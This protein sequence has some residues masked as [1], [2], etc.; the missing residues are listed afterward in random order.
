MKH[1][2]YDS[3]IKEYRT[4]SILH[5]NGNIYIVRDNPILHDLIDTYFMTTGDFFNGHFSVI[6]TS[7]NLSH[8]TVEWNLIGDFYQ[9]D[10]VQIDEYIGVI[11]ITKKGIKIGD[12]QETFSLLDIN[13][14][15]LLGNTNQNNEILEQFNKQKER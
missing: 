1:R 15:K 7:E 3:Y 10:I 4:D 13:R 11:E 12:Y 14:I 8:C 9:N 5:S 2:I 6:D